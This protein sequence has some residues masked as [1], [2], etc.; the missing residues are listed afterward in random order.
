V[1]PYVADLRELERKLKANRPDLLAW[2]RKDV[3]RAQ[4]D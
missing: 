1:I 2:F 4:C 3:E